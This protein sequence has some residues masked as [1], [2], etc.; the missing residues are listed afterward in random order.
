M[1]RIDVM[2]FVRIDREIRSLV[3]LVE[4][5][6][7]SKDRSEAERENTRGVLTKMMPQLQRVGLQVSGSLVRQLHKELQEPLKAPAILSQLHGIERS[8][9]AESALKIFLQVPAAHE[10]LY[11]QPL[12]AFGPTVLKAFPSAKEDLEEASRCVAL[13]RN[14]A[15][16]FHLMRVLEVGLR[17]LMKV[18]KDLPPSSALWGR[19]LTWLETR[20]D[21]NNKFVESAV[22]HLHTIKTAWRNPT[23]HYVE[24]AFAEPEAMVIF[25]ATKAFMQHLATG[26]GNASRRGGPLLC[27]TVRERWQ[28]GLHHRQGRDSRR[29]RCV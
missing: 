13:G 19:M 22:A 17:E 23:M 16:V 29:H 28:P 2:Q 21:T 15:T 25:N 12:Q 3:A 26:C 18:S 7:Q 4:G 9:A 20:K 10:A 6:N 27:G 8:I 1:Q 5:M 11:Q 14:T 24:R